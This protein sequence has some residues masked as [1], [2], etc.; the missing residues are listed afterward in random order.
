MYAAA[1]Q[2][3]IGK[4]RHIIASRS[5][6]SRRGQPS[7]ARKMHVLAIPMW[8]NKSDNYAYLVTDDKTKDAVIIDPAHPEE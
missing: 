7:S 5:V 6:V 2:R 8:V 1:V 3:I 4:P